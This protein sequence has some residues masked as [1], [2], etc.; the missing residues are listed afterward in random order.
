MFQ[1][2]DGKYE[3]L[4][5]EDSILVGGFVDEPLEIIVRGPVPAYIVADGGEIS[6]DKILW[7]QRIETDFAEMN[8]YIYV[9][10]NEDRNAKT[11]ISV[12]AV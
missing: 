5:G 7:Q 3:V 8:Q 9:K 4:V 2:F 12:E 10:P 11:T 1:I 6:T